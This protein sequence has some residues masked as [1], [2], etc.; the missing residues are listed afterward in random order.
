M[1]LLSTLLTDGGGKI[2]RQLRF[3]WNILRQPRDFVRTLSPLGFA[4]QSVIL[5]FMQTLD[6]SLRVRLKPRWRWPFGAWLTSAPEQ[7]QKAPAY[8]P[9]ANQFTRRMAARM[10]AIPGSAINEV[11]LDVPT[12]AHILGGC[13]IAPD[14]QQGVI[15]LQNRV[16]GYQNLRICDGSMVP[17]NLGVNPSLTITSLSEQAMSQVPL[18][19][20]AHFRHFPFEHSWQVTELINPEGVLHE[21]A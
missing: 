18:K 3:I 1:G 16:F 20:G 19:P 21:S 17:A 7:G 8:I 11:L 15:D 6:N 12:T 9:L 14:P 2:P 5:L 13:A 4:R 10:N